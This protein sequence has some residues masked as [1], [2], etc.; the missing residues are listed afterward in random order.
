MAHKLMRLVVLCLIPLGSYAQTNKTFTIGDSMPPITF[1][2]VFNQPGVSLFPKDYK[3]KLVIIDFWSHW[4]GTCIEAFPKMEKLQKEFGDK[5]KI[6]LVTPDKKEDVVKLFKRFKIPELTIL[7]ADT[8]LS[9]MF[10]HI[11]VPHHVWIN[12]DGRIQF[13]T[14][15]Y[16][17]TS[18]NVSKVLEGKK[19]IL[20]VKKELKDIDM[21]ADLWKE[22]N[23]RFQ[24]YIINYAFI[25][26]KVTENWEHGF[27]FSKDTI[28]NTRGFKFVNSA[29]IDLYKVA[30]EGT[31]DYQGGYFGMGNRVQLIGPR[32]HAFL[33]YPDNSDSIPAWEERNIICYESKWK[34]Q[35]DSM[36]FKYLQDDAN[37]FFP[38]SVKEETKEVTCY[39]LQPA[40]G[41]TSANSANEEK[42]FEYTDSS[43][44]LQNMPVTYI[45]ESLNHQE[46][47]K[48][49]PVIDE[50]NY[51]SGIDIHLTNSFT[52]IATLKKQ[53]LQN[54]L[55]LEKAVR[56]I[57][58]LVISDR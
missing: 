49:I 51:R 7:Y 53:L 21:D 56:K 20:P 29:L 24:K 15:G 32:V 37:R 39:I 23:G 13:I 50:T 26:S 31:I 55:L 17:A 14:D 44:I 3:G 38:F 42:I 40:P 36:A 12:P 19:I 27:S 34:I 28:H 48:T 35:D 25:M 18:Q 8:I 41:F 46:L 11:T 57:R 22:G 4:C 10:P 6:L 52:N 16:N 45:I 43:F 1:N 33:D 30:F 58:M 9:H 54:G 2:N 5:I 47:F